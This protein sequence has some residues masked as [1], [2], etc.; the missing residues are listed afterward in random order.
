MCKGPVAA[1]VASL[2]DRHE[3]SR[4]LCKI[5]AVEVAGDN[6]PQGAGP[7]QGF[8][9]ISWEKLWVFFVCFLFLREGVGSEQGAE[10]DRISGRAE[11]EKEN[12]GSCL[13]EV[14]LKLT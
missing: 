7:G 10:R 12:K 1:Q 11:R 8:C 9:F 4:A 5:M 14:E 6:T 3:G 13:P 2:R